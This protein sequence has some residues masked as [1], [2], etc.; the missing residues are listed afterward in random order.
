MQFPAQARTFVERLQ[1]VER[2]IVHLTTEH[3]DVAAVLDRSDL[4]QVRR[5]KRWE[6]VSWNPRMKRLNAIRNE[7]RAASGLSLDD[8][9][10]IKRGQASDTTW[11][12]K[13]AKAIETL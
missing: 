1:F 13:V 7:L 9:L 3:N 2:A 6:K 4:E 10:Q 11:D 5:F 12:A 8:C